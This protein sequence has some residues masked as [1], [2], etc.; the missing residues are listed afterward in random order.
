[1][2]GDFLLDTNIISAGFKEEI[3]IADLVPAGQRATVSAH[4]AG[5]LLYGLQDL[6]GRRRAA[7]LLFLEDV[8]STF[9]VLD[10]THTTAHHY[11]LIRHQL[12]IAGNPIPENDIWIAAT[13]IEHD[14]TLV[15]RD[16][17]FASVVGLSSVRW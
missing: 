13:A 16:T 15:T 9:P 11:G 10:V 8:F 6:Q 3:V 2:S 5:E 1:M 12:R 4:V 14:L 17:H 7:L